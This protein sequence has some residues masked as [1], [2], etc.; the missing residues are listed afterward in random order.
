MALN[1][2][3]AKIAARVLHNTH[4]A[5]DN[6]KFKFELL[7][8]AYGSAAVEADFET[9]CVEHMVEPPQYPITSYLKVVDSRLGTEPTKADTKDPRV[10]DML[11]FTYDL[12]G[13]LPYAK[14]VA[15]LLVDFEIEE[16]K[17]ALTEYNGL[18]DDKEMKSGMRS[19]FADGGAA[20]VIYA[21]RKRK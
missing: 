2:S 5:P 10:A 6:C 19:F 3:L 17:A 12:T 11:A 15:Q 7:A 16:L 21:R 9:W 13:T 8:E 14:H 4:T 18:L 1:K 20:A